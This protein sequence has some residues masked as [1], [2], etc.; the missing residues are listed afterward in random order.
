MPLE[1]VRCIPTLCPNRE[2][3]KEAEK[4]KEGRAVVVVGVR[5]I[6]AD[7]TTPTFRT[8]ALDGWPRRVIGWGP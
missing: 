8:H 5:G 7:A 2:A 4:A 3:R 6:E 1:D